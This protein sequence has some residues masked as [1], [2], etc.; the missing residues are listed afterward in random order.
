MMPRLSQAPLRLR[1]AK[2]D[3]LA[4]VPGNLLPYK[5]A[6]QSVANRLPSRAVLIV[7]PNRETTQKDT[8]L[9]VAKLLARA[10]HQVRVI[11][12]AEV[13]R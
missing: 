11:S 2:L 6:W 3:N 1:R 4:L 8:L 9:T 10:G 5:K 13:S 12:A 7:L